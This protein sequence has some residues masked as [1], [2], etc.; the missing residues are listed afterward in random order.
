[1]TIHPTKLALEGN[2]L[3]IDWSDG[4]RRRY[5]TVEL[6]QRC[7]CAT[8]DTARAESRPLFDESEFPAPKLAIRQMT[9]VGNYA[10]KI[11]FGDGH[12]TGIYTFDRLR[13]LG[14]TVNP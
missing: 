9:P 4:Q 7:P 1:M 13:Q 6:R 3:L 12:D 2:A 11:H 8:C 14:E 10:Y 5:D